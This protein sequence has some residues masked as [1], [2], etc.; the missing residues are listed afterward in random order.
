[1]LRIRLV[2]NNHPSVSTLYLAGR[3]CPNCAEQGSRLQSWRRPTIFRVSGVGHGVFWFFPLR[4]ELVFGK[5]STT[6]TTTKRIG[7]FSTCSQPECRQ[8]HSAKLYHR[9]GKKAGQVQ[10]VPCQ[11]STTN[12]KGDN[13]VSWPGS[14]LQR[15]TCCV[16][17]FTTT[18][19]QFGTRQS[20]RQV[21]NNVMVSSNLSNCSLLTV[22]THGINWCRN[23]LVRSIEKQ[24]TWTIQI[25]F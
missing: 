19:K 11:S 8:T 12:N 13:D 4:T 15:S 2:A 20:R 16:V 1:M 17:T 5:R 9:K 23:T 25:S 22:W 24:R 14:F 6:K 7:M 21:A 10:Y 18:K 3:N